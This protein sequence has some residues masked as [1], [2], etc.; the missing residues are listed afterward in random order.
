MVDTFPMGRNMAGSVDIL[1]WS[2]KAKFK[3][4]AFWMIH[5][6]SGLVFLGLCGKEGT[7]E[8][9]AHPKQNKNED[10]W[11]TNTDVWSTCGLWVLWRMY[12]VLTKKSQ[13]NFFRI[14]TDK[15][16]EDFVASEEQD[17]P[18]TKGVYQDHRHKHLSRP[19]QKTQARNT[20]QRLNKE[21]HLKP[22]T[23]SRKVAI[24]TSYRPR[25]ETQAREQDN[26]N[27]HS[28]ISEAKES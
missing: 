4:I 3:Y 26:N 20:T 17:K 23:Q 27:S 14:I 1:I 10:S 11:N 13:W 24:D 5:V 16:I 21:T 18:E 12:V 22:G 15:L 2:F 19:R 8:G 6:V 25:Q 28:N 9:S 7:L